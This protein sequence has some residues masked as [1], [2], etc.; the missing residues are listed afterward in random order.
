M[1]ISLRNA[2]AA[3][4]LAAALP[5]GLQ[6]QSDS[7][8]A[9]SAGGQS[10]FR[11]NTDGNVG[12]G[13]SSPDRRLAVVGAMSVTDTIATGYGIKFADGSIQLTAA[14]SASGTSLNTPSTLVARDANGAFAAG[15]ITAGG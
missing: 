6:A 3:M 5:A 2:L 11:V 8:L 14:G 15:W 13:N 7:L 10:L 12:I 4:A 9:V 1:M